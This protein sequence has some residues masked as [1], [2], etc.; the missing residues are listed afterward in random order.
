VWIARQRANAPDTTLAAGSV[1]IIHRPPFDTPEPIAGPDWVIYEDRHL[2]AINKP[3]GL[4]VEMTPWDSKRHIR[5]ALERWLAER[6]GRP[7]PLHLAHRLDRDTS[8]VLLLVKNPRVNRGIYQI[9][10]AGEVHKTYLAHAIGDPTFDQQ[11]I[12]TGHGR[13]KHGLFRIYPLDEIGREL[14][15]GSKIK[16]MQTRLCVQQRFGTSTLVL[17]E[18]LTGRTHQIRLHLSYVGHPLVGDPKYGGPETWEGYPTL[19]H[20][21]HAL[22]MI[23][24]HPVTKQQLILEAA[25]PAWS[26]TKS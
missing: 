20:R 17:A 9:F 6:E 13:S 4:Y 10:T 19:H 7:M 11:L 25:A 18:P 24:P 8:G 3:P 23:L 15:D 1:V 22:R 12:E 16:R 26:S 2:I 14:P 21:L 5:G